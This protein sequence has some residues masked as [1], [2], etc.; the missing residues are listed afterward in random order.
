MQFPSKSKNTNLQ[1]II[2]KKQQTKQGQPMAKIGL[3]NPVCLQPGDKVALSRRIVSFL[4]FSFFHF[5]QNF[6]PQKQTFETS[7]IEKQI[8]KI[9]TKTG[10]TLAFNWMG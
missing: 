5:F 10:Q 9:H 4:S 8:H 2:L 1:K 6:Q 3:T 7:K